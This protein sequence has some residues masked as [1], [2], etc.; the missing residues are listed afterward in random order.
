MA[1]LPINRSAQLDIRAV[2]GT[3]LAG[4]ALSLSGDLSD[5]NTYNAS[6]VST[7]DGN[8]DAVVRQPASDVVDGS[9][10]QVGMSNARLLLGATVAKDDFLT[11]DSNGAWRK[12]STLTGAVRCYYVAFEPGNAGDLIWA[13]PV[14]S[15]PVALG[16]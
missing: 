7:A 15:R 1:S 3:L 4:Q 6:L 11:V 16:L 10:L 8:V 13:H 12:V 5:T 14:G 2:T 9:A